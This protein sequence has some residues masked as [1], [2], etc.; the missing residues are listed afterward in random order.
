MA[1]YDYRCR[2]CSHE[3]EHEQPIKDPPLEE[4]PRCLTCGLYRLVSG[5]SFVLKG[6]GWAADGYGPSGGPPPK[7]D[8]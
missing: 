6:T 5:G 2:V 4:C 3:F 7:D 8:R 1:V